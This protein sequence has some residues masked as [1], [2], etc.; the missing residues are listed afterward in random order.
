M[1]PVL[2]TKRSIIHLYK[3]H[4][5]NESVTVVTLSFLQFFSCPLFLTSTYFFEFVRKNVARKQKFV[6]KSVKTILKFVRKSV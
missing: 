4:V 2:G 3:E 5:L 6:R 1:R